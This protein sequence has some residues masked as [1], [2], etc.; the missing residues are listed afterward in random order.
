MPHN[1]FLSGLQ[2]LDLGGA[3]VTFSPPFLFSF[4]LLCFSL[5]DSG[6][7]VRSDAHL[8]PFPFVFLMT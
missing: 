1:F 5:L 7:S 2:T 8:P 4:P 3:R 6:F